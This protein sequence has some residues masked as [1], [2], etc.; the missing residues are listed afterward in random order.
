MR[1]STKPAAE[2]WLPARIKYELDLKGWSLRRLS[3]ANGY[4]EWAMKQTLRRHLPAC[5]AIIAKVIG[6]SPDEIWP[7]RYVDGKPINPVRV[8]RRGPH[9]SKAKS[10]DAGD[11][12]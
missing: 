4:S 12:L 1:N 9:G 3:L 5:E 11:R 8:H 7:S 10:N 6:V 2:D